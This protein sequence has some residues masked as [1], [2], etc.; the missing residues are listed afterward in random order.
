MTP[1][2]LSVLWRIAEP[3]L[4]LAPLFAAACWLW[5]QWQGLKRTANEELAAHAAKHGH[6]VR[7][8]RQR[9]WE[10]DEL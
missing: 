3:F 1:S 8:N 5:L 2:L 9:V 4:W 7:R 6:A 10:G